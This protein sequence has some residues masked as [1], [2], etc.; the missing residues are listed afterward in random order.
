MDATDLN[1]LRQALAKHTTAPT[2]ICRVCLGATDTTVAHPAGGVVFSY[3]VHSKCGG[4][5]NIL[6][7]SW[8]LFVPFEPAVWAKLVVDTL[9]I[10]DE[11]GLDVAR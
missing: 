2:G 11:V 9:Q 4:I 10:E 8:R 7:N 1:Q 3:C 5:Y 6:T